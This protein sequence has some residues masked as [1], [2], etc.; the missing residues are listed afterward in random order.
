MECYRA[1]M[2]HAQETQTM[3]SASSMASF[4]GKRPL[5]RT[6]ELYV[7]RYLEGGRKSKCRIIGHFTD[8]H[9]R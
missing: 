3:H 4:K 9:R 6:M 8:F 7:W 5:G 2:E 1:N